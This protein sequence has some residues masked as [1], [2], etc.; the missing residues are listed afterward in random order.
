VRSEERIE[1]RLAVVRSTVALTNDAAVL[2][3][4]P[5]LVASITTLS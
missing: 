4:L 2:A 5:V 1:E 3:T